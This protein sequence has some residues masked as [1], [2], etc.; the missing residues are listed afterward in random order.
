MQARE[1]FQDGLHVVQLSGEIDLR[2]SPELRDLLTGHAEQKRP[3]LLL[4]LSEVE[5]IDSSGL[6]TMVEYVQRSLTFGG[7]FGVSGLSDRLRTIF[8]I[9]R[10]GEVFPIF[11]SLDEARSALVSPT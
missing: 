6:A 5:Y 9:A 3:A 8:D 2:S 4:D 1:H 10:L 11:T 7:R